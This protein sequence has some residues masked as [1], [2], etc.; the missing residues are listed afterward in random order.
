MC[1]II[2]KESG[3]ELN[4]SLFPIIESASKMNPDGLGY[5]L[6]RKNEARIFIRKGLLKDIDVIEE[7]KISDI[8]PDDELVIHLR[9]A[10]S[11]LEDEN[12]C[13]PFVVANE[14]KDIL[15]N[16]SFVTLPCLSH[17]GI[18]ND[19]SYLEDAFSDTYYF[20]KE[21]LS[22]RE[23][24]YNEEKLRYLTKHLSW[25]KLA[26]LFPQ[27][28][29]KMLLLGNF[30]EEGNYKVSNRGYSYTSPYYKEQTNFYD[31]KETRILPKRTIEEV[32]GE[33]WPYYCY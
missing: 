22:P 1:L 2:A 23:V 25:N 5:M 18:F 24:L 12:N 17:N 4:E 28:D 11:G 21:Y 20:I 26:I 16:N 10:T 9:L 31:E 15:Q 3:K 30:F 14:E 19:F 33:D 32:Y 29:K 8:L 7:L 27:K 13:H 6:K